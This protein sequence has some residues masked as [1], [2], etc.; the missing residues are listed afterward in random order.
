MLDCK[1]IDMDRMLWKDDWVQVDRPLLAENVKAA[2]LEDESWVSDGVYFSI[3]D[4][5]YGRATDIICESV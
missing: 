5:F 4:S 1:H 3:R 2:T